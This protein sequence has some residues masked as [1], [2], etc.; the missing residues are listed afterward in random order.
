MTNAVFSTGPITKEVSAAVE[1]HH[2]V[3]L[4]SDGKV[5]HSSGANFPYGSV[6]QNADPDAGHLPNHVAVNTHQAVVNIETSDEF[7]AGDLVYVGAN[8]VATAS[9]TVAV[10]IAE[11]PSQGGRIRVHQFHPSIFAGSPEA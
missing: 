6:R 8:G 7:S 5:A 9:G 2:F 11:R 1:P 4:D 10:G 3:D